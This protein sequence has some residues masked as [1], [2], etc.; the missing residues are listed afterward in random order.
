M[1]VSAAL[2][3][4]VGQGSLLTAVAIQRGV[5]T[6]VLCSR[7]RC[8]LR[9]RQEAPLWPFIF[10]VTATFRPLGCAQGGRGGLL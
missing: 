4:E 6:D 7:V 8:C 10:F 1:A 3:D 5:L 2:P 9:M